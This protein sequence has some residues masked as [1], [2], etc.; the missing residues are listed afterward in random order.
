L[1]GVAD[2]IP[3]TVTLTIVSAA[4]CAALANYAVPSGTA[5]ARAATPYTPMASPI[6]TI[7]AASKR[8]M[9]PAR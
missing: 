6:R 7:F 8:P 2:G 3:L 9:P 4:S 5:T 1:N